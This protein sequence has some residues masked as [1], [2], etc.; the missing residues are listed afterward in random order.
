MVT[1]AGTLDGRIAVV[2]GGSSGIGLA[3]AEL[4]AR[5]GAV[6]Y[7]TGRRADVL[8]EAGRIVGERARTV[9]GDA[10]DLDDI[11]RLAD[12][13]REQEGVVDIVVTSAGLADIVTLE[14]ATPEHFDATFDLNVRGTFFTVQRL[15][16]LMTRGGSIVL[17]SSAQ[18]GRGN[19]G[20]SAYAAS[21]AAVRSFAKTWSTELGPRG[22]RVNSLSPGV[23]DT[24]I[25]G[26]QFATPALHEE[27][28][29]KFG[30]NVKLGR[31]GTPA[32]LAEGV[33][34]LAS[35]AGSYTNG[36]D[37]LIDGGR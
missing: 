1:M 20:F 8:A 25:L 30:A 4:M 31:V 21:K 2:T 12:L 19:A 29:A 15:L 18:A 5:E 37:L 36:V 14:D 24:P 22:I 13:V 27:A 10:S 34:Y 28:M 3:A 23:V 26:P 9:Q 7:L 11:D 6:V 32:E 16:P 33:L 35:D 17:I